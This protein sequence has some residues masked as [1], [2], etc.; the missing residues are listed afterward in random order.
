MRRKVYLFIFLL[1]LGEAMLFSVN[2]PFIASL[3]SDELVGTVYSLS[4]LA[5]IALLALLPIFLR[6]ASPSTILPTLLFASALSAWGVPWLGMPWS[7]GALILFIALPQVAPAVSDTFIE[8]S[9]KARQRGRVI[10]AELTFMNLAFVIAPIIAGRII[11]TAGYR[12]L[13]LIS[14]F[15]FILALISSLSLKSATGQETKY[16]PGSLWRG[17]REAWGR[18]NLR[19]V[20]M[21]QF[22]LQFFFSWMIIYT[23][24]YLINKFDFGFADLGIIFSIMLLPYILLEY[25]L[26]KIADD[27]LGEKEI[28]S[29]GFVLMAIIVGAIPFITSSSMWVWVVILFG[30]RIGSAMVESMSAIYFYKKVEAKDV[31]LLALFRDM[32][33][34]AYLVGPIAASVIIAQSG[35][36]SLFPVLAIFMIV[37]ALIATRLHDTR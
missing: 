16:S 21:T 14:G 32:R 3:V 5:A 34:I 1:T 6:R 28:L 33:P 9:S 17:L 24:I 11:A 18:S 13:Y 29:G 10:G 7:L 15:I 37:G 36:A 31:D 30:T 19:F 27:R 25:P 23:P 26:G 20:I 4:S 35:I 2:S 22:L 12:P 8:A